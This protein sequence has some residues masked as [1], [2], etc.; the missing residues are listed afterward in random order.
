MENPYMDRVLMYL[1]SFPVASEVSRRVGKKSIHTRMEAWHG[2]VPVPPWRRT[3]C[4]LSGFLSSK[5]P[6]DGIMD[7]R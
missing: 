4:V 6:I 1:A 3:P 5:S 2:S 7:C